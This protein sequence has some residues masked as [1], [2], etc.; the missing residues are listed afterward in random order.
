LG[1]F[2]SLGVTQDFTG[3]SSTL[4]FSFR[5]GPQRFQ[6]RIVIPIAENRVKRM[7]FPNV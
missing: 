7:M 5:N 4:R 1:N 3:Y 6:I 2:G